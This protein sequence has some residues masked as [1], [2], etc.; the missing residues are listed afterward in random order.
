MPVNGTAT[1][2]YRNEGGVLPPFPQL[3]LK[4]GI[5]KWEEVVLQD[6]NPVPELPGW[7][8]TDLALHEV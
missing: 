2:Y 1:L 3:Q 4:A 8:A 5:N 7:W 6:M